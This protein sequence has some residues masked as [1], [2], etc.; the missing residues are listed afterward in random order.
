MKTVQTLMEEGISGVALNILVFGPQVQYIADDERTK[1]LQNKRI[2][3]RQALEES[4]HFVKYAEDIVD[5][6]LPE[7][8]NNAMLQEI[9]IMHEYDLIVTLVDSPG[10]IVEASL[11]CSRPTLASKATLFLDQ[12]YMG[13]LVA[14]TCQAGEI[15]GADFQTYQYPEDLTECHLL[16]AVKKRVTKV[17]TVKFLS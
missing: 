11:I 9:A 5:P 3:I 4:G 17:Q 2:E 12:S 7:P 10:S 13:G 8:A 6:N 15:Q 14:Q 16:G 1:N